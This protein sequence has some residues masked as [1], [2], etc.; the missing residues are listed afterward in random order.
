MCLSSHSVTDFPRPEITTSFCTRS[1]GSEAQEVCFES[2]LLATI[3]CPWMS[4]TAVYSW[5]RCTL[6]RSGSTPYTTRSLRP[7]L[8]VPLSIHLFHK[9]GQLGPS[10]MSEAKTDWHRAFVGA[11]STAASRHLSSFSECRS[12]L[13]GDCS[14][15][16]V[17]C[18]FG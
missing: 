5:R 10:W 16:L 1:L 9:P 17:Y 3:A 13:W 18:A 7:V 14:P 4:S 2:W 12:R 6:S 15:S 8:L 11:P